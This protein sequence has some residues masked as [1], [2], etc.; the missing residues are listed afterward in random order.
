MYL[1]DALYD[2]HWGPQT[3]HFADAFVAENIVAM[4]V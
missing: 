3:D 2:R 4:T 1:H